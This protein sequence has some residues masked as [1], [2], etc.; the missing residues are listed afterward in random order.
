MSDL[1]RMK[2]FPVMGQL[3]TVAY[4]PFDLVKAHEGQARTNHSQTVQ[5]LADRGGLDCSELAAVLEDREWHHIS[6]EDAW[7][8]ILKACSDHMNT[9]ATEG[10]WIPVAER[11]PEFVSFIEPSEDFIG[12]SESFDVLAYSEYSGLW[13]KT[14]YVKYGNA[15]HGH[16]KDLAYV[17]HWKEFIPPSPTGGEAS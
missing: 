11:L 14:R 6:T 3:R 16:F 7:K 9:R 5:G 12:M 2:M 13:G 1:A 4:V 10:V 17:S 8:I 15:A